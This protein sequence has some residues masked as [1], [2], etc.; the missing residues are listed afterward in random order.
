[1]VNLSVKFKFRLQ[2]P[3]SSVTAQTFASN[4]AR[5]F[6]KHHSCLLCSRIRWNSFSFIMGT[7]EKL[8]KH[9]TDGDI[10]RKT[11]LIGIFSTFN[12]R[13]QRKLVVCTS[14][15][16]TEVVCGRWRNLKD[17]KRL[18]DRSNAFFV[19]RTITSSVPSS[20]FAQ[21]KQKNF[22]KMERMKNSSLTLTKRLW[23]AHKSFVPTYKSFRRE[24]S[25]RTSS[26]E[27]LSS[28]ALLFPRNSLKLKVFGRSL[29]IIKQFFIIPLHK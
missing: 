21:R 16:T 6:T 28:R 19:R 15:E 8:E 1:M 29:T 20:K 10:I 26:W 13:Q 23:Q 9:S 12:S 18:H 11:L 22:R 4:K 24:T 3:G 2:R 17:A 27:S 5:T 14:W 25:A 7:L